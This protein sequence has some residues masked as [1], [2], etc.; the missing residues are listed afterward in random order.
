ME[1]I[2]PVYEGNGLCLTLAK[3]EAIDFFIGDE[4]VRF[5][6]MDVNKTKGRIVFKASKEVEIKRVNRDAIGEEYES[7]GINK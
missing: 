5:T 6:I 7:V 2:K 4:K 3:G 1:Y